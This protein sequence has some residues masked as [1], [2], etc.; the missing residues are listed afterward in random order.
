ME[1]SSKFVI[2]S[3]SCRPNSKSSESL[4]GTEIYLQKPCTHIC[5]MGIKLSCNNILQ[6]PGHVPPAGQQAS[7][8][9]PSQQGGP[10]APPPGAQ[11]NPPIHEGVAA[12]PPPS[13]AGHLSGPPPPGNSDFTRQTAPQPPNQPSKYFCGSPFLDVLCVTYS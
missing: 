4:A 6:P 2:F 13:P 7:M 9:P 11:S 12:Q 10:P 1:S 3:V 5:C 8:P